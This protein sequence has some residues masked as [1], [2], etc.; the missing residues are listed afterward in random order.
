MSSNALIVGS[1]AFDVIMSYD[2][3]FA[4]CLRANDS[5]ALNVGFYINHKLTEFGG[6]GGN[7]AYNMSIFGHKPILIARAGNDLN[8]YEE[9]LIEHEINTDYIIRHLDLETA[10]A[11]ITTD[12]RSNQITSFYPGAMDS[13]DTFTLPKNEEF[14]IS[15]LS[16][17]DGRF[18]KS[19]HDAIRHLPYIFDPG[20]MV[21]GLSPEFLRSGIEHAYLTIVNSYECDLLKQYLNMSLPELAKFAKILIVTHGSEGSSLYIKGKR[22]KI[23][24]VAVKDPKDPTGCGDAYRAG[25]IVGLLNGYPLDLCAKIGS[26]TASFAVEYYGT[27]NHYFSLE[28][29]NQRLFDTYGFSFEYVDEMRI[30]DDAI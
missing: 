14:V 22:T 7:I 21:T 15:I 8:T 5:G 4:D 18:M 28:E 20:Q 10:V 12:R 1:L 16:P 26:T 2:G 23:P 27:Q 13:E 19:A 30:V 9:W 11:Y 6:C 24:A 29:F 3:V 17:E 25:L